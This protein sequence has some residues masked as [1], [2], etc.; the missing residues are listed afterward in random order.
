MALTSDRGYFE[1]FA[2]GQRLRHARGATIGEV[3]NGLVSKMVMNTAQGHWNEHFSMNGE[4]PAGRVVFGLVTGSVVFG[5]ASQDVA[6]Q[7][8]AELGCTGLRFFSPVHHG[9]TVYALTEV[10]EVSPADRPDA[11]VVRFKHWGL[12]HDGRIVFEGERTVLLKRR[13]SW[14]GATTSS[15]GGIP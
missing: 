10:L 1:D 9:D 12:A 7:A 14:A 15:P 5:L 4:P 3:E 2:V 13:S 8:L 11:G 6:E